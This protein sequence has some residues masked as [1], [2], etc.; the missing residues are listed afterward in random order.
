MSISTFHKKKVIIYIYI[1]IKHNYKYVNLQ[2]V[3][4]VNYYRLTYVFSS[5]T[6][7][8]PLWRCGEARPVKTKMIILIGP[9]S[10]H[11]PRIDAFG[12]SKSFRILKYAFKYIKYIN[13][14][15]LYFINIWLVSNWSNS[16][17]FLT[18][19]KL[20]K[21]AEES[22]LLWEASRKHRAIQK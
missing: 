19:N 4:E 9:S 1:T 20:R 15:N 13:Q 5:P 18:S 11:P 21:N 17:S 16:L 8:T 3:K 14:N 12:S 2:N 22:I 10:E 6:W 7:S